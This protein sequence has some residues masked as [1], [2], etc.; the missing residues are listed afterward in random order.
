VH[1]SL[2]CAALP[3]VSIFGR[4]PTLVGI[5]V[6]VSTLALGHLGGA[7]CWRSAHVARLYS[8]ALESDG[9]HLQEELE[10][11][12]VLQLLKV[13]LWICQ[14]GPHQPISL[15]AREQSMGLL[16]DAALDLPNKA[17]VRVADRWEHL[18]FGEA[19]TFDC[20]RQLGEAG[21]EF[22]LE[23]RHQLL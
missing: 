15:P 19:I 7:W 10:Q 3:G 20:L 5:P 6:A 8:L 16:A 18:S 2:R 1:L 12:L 21:K 11:V 4:A 23:F 9:L 17:Q 13:S 14:V 22:G